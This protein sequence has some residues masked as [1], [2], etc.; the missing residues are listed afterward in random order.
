MQRLE[1]WNSL[2]ID[3]IEAHRPYPFEWGVH[4]CA[5]LSADAVMAVVGIDL[6]RG[7]RSNYNDRAG[8]TKNLQQHGFSSHVEIVEQA[9]QEI[10]PSETLVGDLAVVKTRYGPATAPIIGSEVAVYATKGI[11]IQSLSEVL[12]AFRVEIR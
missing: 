6:A 1:G 12:R 2:L 11:T 9:F 5:I 3:A 7:Y 4:D 10:H 8:A